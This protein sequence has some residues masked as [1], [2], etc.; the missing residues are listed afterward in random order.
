MRPRLSKSESVVVMGT[1]HK[2]IEAGFGGFLGGCDKGGAGHGPELRS[3]E[4]GGAPLGAGD[5]VALGVA[6]LG[7]DQLPPP[8]QG[9][10]EVKVIHAKERETTVVRQVTGLLTLLAGP[11]TC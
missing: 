3:D 4:N 2:H 1:G 11:A 5:P 6:P 7:A 10:M 8:G 9:V